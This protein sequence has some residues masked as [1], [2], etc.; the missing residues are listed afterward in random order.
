M[1]WFNCVGSSRATDFID[2]EWLKL[3]WRRL[4]PYKEGM[5]NMVL[6]RLANTGYFN[7]TTKASLWS[8]YK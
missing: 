1:I 7:A 4:D 5:F 3:L 6:R 8:N 2:M